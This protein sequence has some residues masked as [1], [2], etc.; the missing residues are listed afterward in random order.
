V[1]AALATDLIQYPAPFILGISSEEDENRDL[2]GSLPTDVTLIDLDVGRVILA[3]SFG[4]DNEM[5]RRSA[6]AE[7]TAR[8]LRSQVL[9]LAQALGSVFGASL[10]P[11]TWCCDSPSPKQAPEEV[12]KSWDSATGINSLRTSAQSF[13]DELLQ[14]MNIVTSFAFAFLFA[15]HL[16][17]LPEGVTSCCYWIEEVAQSYGASVEPTVLFDEDKFFGIKNQRASKACTHLFPK[18]QNGEL[19]LSLDDFDLVLESFLRCQSMSSYISSRPKTEMV[20]Y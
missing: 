7:A 4:Q 6:D 3:P 16:L 1:P 2:L 18:D 15:N 20:Y 11:E 10:R 9:Y 5:V 17:S 8:A 19:A 12:G 13:I 14:G